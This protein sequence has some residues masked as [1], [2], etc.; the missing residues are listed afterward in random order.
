MKGMEK[1]IQGAEEMA[2][3]ATA[4]LADLMPQKDSA[5]VIALSGELGAGKTTFTQALA[6]TLAVE[7]TVNSPTFV[8][9]KVYMLSGQRWQRL[10]HVDAYRLHHVDEVRAIGWSEIV[11]DPANLVVIEWPENMH[12]AIPASAHAIRIE[13]G[14]DEARTIIYGT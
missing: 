5:T 1:C 2:R 11:A 3:F 8:I 9:E 7:E 14:E 4:F 13:I 10:V 12:S 6:A